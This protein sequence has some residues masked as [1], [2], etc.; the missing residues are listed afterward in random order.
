V[1]EVLRRSADGEEDFCIPLRLEQDNHLPDPRA[2]LLSIDMTDRMVRALFTLGLPLRQERRIRLGALACQA[3]FD[4][5]CVELS[6]YLDGY[7]RPEGRFL[8][9]FVSDKAKG[10]RTLPEDGSAVRLAPGD[11]LISG[12]AVYRFEG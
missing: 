5:D 1:V 3:R 7:R 8:P 12:C 4:G 6:D 11:R 9:V 10:F 2:R